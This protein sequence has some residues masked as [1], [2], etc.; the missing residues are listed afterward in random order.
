LEFPPDFQL[1]LVSQS[2]RRHSLLRDLEIPFTVAQSAATELSSGRSAK[3]LAEVN[4][5][6]KVRGARLP[7]GVG[8]GAFV[9]GTDTVVSLGSRIMGKPASAGEAEDM[10]TA[11]AGQTHRV[12]SGVALARLGGASVDDPSTVVRVASACTRVAFAQLDKQQVAA[13]VETGEWRG[14]AGGYA[15]Q[16]SAAL[17]VRGLRGEYTS[18]VGLP[19][20]LLFGLFSA[21]G[22]DLVRRTWL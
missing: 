11:L 2:P 8:S 4:A 9:L 19:L 3:G 1:I 7:E 13:Y 14:K 21:M 17:F 6:G 15:V 16:G 5:L 20:H 12:I 22:F 18:V 10:L